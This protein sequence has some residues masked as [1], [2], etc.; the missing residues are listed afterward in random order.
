MTQNEKL[1]EEMLQILHKITKKGRKIKKTLDLVEAFDKTNFAVYS[2]GK[3]KINLLNN[4]EGFPKSVRYSAKK[5]DS[6]VSNIARYFGVDPEKN[7]LE[8]VLWEKDAHLLFVRKMISK[9]EEFHVRLAW[10]F[11][12]TIKNLLR[13]NLS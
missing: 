3:D 12:G 2:I 1:L 8:F 5:G 4:V 7:L 11:F 6:A 13:L 10:T 9:D